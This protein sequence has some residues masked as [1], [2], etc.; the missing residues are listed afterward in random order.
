MVNST[1]IDAYLWN[2]LMYGMGKYGVDNAN[3]DIA[4]LTWYIHTDRASADFLR[5]LI[6]SKPYMVARKLH[7]GGSYDETIDR[8]KKYIGYKPE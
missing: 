3:S 6:A 5:K 7:N 1:A 4:P 8:I 2:V